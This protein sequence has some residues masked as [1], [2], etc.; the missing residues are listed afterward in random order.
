MSTTSI[1][2]PGT[3]AYWAAQREAV[4][5]VG[6][7]QNDTLIP[8]EELALLRRIAAHRLATRMM[9]ALGHDVERLTAIVLRTPGLFEE[10]VDED[11]EDEDADPDGPPHGQDWCRKGCQILYGME[12]GICGYEGRGVWAS[13]VNTV[14]EHCCHCN[15]RTR[16]SPE[17]ICELCG[18]DAETPDAPVQTPAFC[19]RDCGPVS[20]DAQCR[21]CRDLERHAQGASVQA[22]HE[23]QAA[24]AHGIVG[25]GR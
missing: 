16:Q 17:G 6:A 15:A 3:P 20:T 21:L 2:I 11:D 9:A 14:A 1:P 4:A 8:D 23:D 25:G 18:K 22:G 13:Q 10:D 12:C 24:S 7:W 19:F 5:L